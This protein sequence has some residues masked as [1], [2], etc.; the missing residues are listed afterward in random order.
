MIGIANPAGVCVSNLERTV[1]PTL[2]PWS[3]AWVR[4]E[5][6]RGMNGSAEDEYI[7]HLI[8]AAIAR[9]ERFT[10]LSLAPQTWVYSLD[11]FPT[12]R[13]FDLPRP[14]VSAVT[15]ITYL[16]ANGDR[17]TFDGASPAPYV[18]TSP[19]APRRS[20][21]SLRTDEVWPTALVEPGSVEITF[22]AGFP[23]AGTSPDVVELPADLAHG[24]LL[25]IGELYKQRS[26]S[27]HAFS[28]NPALIRALDLWRPYR[29][30]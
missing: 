16:D 19:P 29:V 21:V 17:Q 18:W 27:V 11:R 23:A 22:E 12:T 10:R 24:L 5:H 25:T 20:R 8:D 30:L 28:Q 3:V 14:P 1:A 7:G 6:L 13:S 2:A 26:E 15:S 9:C 4:D